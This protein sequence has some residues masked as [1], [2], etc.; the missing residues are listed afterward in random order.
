MS[1]TY[2]FKIIITI[3]ITIIIFLSF[4]ETSESQVNVYDNDYFTIENEETTIN[5]DNKKDKLG[6]V[7]SAFESKVFIENLGQLTRKIPFN[8][9]TVK[10]YANEENVKMMFDPKGIT[11]EI[12][13]IEIDENAYEEWMEE[14]LN[15]YKSYQDKDRHEVEKEKKLKEKIYTFTYDYIRMEWEN[16]GDDVQIVP[17]DEGTEKFHFFNYDDQNNSVYGARGYKK[18][19]IKNL[20]PGINVIYSF[21][22]EEGVKYR[23]DLEPGADPFF[24]IMTYSGQV[25]LIKDKNGNIVLRSSKGTV[26]DHAP[27]SWQLSQANIIASEFTINENSVGFNLTGIDPSLPVTIDPWVVNITGGTINKG[28]QINCDAA[29]NTYVYG[30][31]TNLSLRK[32]DLVGT[33]L[34]TYDAGWGGSFWPG[35]M[36]VETNGT[37]YICNA[38]AQGWMQKIDNNGNNIFNNMNGCNNFELFC[39][40]FNND[41]SQLVSGTYA[42]DWGTRVINT[43]DGTCSN[44]IDDNSS[45]EL[46]GLAISPE[47]NWYSLSEGTNTMAGSEVIAFAPDFTNI[48]KLPS[49]YDWSNFPYSGPS[50]AGVQSI[51]GGY[52]PGGQNCIDASWCWFY[53]YN[54]KTIMKRDALT[55]ALISQINVPDGDVHE[56]NSGGMF[57]DIITENSGIIV[58]SCDN[59]FVGTTVGIDKYDRDLNFITS[60]ATPAEVY[61]VNFDGLGN[62]VACGNGFAGAFDGLDP[63]LE[64]PIILDIVGTDAYCG[65][66]GTAT[67]DI[68]NNCNFDLEYLWNTG[69]TTDSIGELCEG[70]YWLTVTHECRQWTDSV[71]IEGTAPVDFF[72][73]FDVDSASCNLANGSATAWPQNG[74]GDYIYEWNTVPPQYEQT[75]INLAAGQYIVTVFDNGNYCEVTDT[76]TI[77]Q[78]TLLTPGMDV[79]HI[80][81][82]GECDGM[83]TATTT[84]GGAPPVSWQWDTNPVQTTETITGLCAGI[85]TVIIT[86]ANGCTF[87]AGDTITEPPLLITTTT[88]TNLSCYESCDGTA[89]V[90]ANGGTPPYTFSWNTIPVQ[91][92]SDATNLCAGDYTVI[93]TDANGCTSS[94]TVTLLQPTPLTSTITSTD[95]LC[96]GGDLGTIDLYVEGGTPPY[97]YFWQPDSETSQDLNG[98][99]AGDYSV[100]ITDANGCTTTDGILIQEPYPIETTMNGTNLLCFEDAA[101][102]SASV[103]ATGGTQPYTYL[104]SNGQVS[105]LIY[106]IQAGTYYV[107]VT[108]ANG[109]TAVDNIII[110]EPPELVVVIP[111]PE[112]ICIGETVNLIANVSGGTLPYSYYWNNGITTQTNSVSP[113]IT[114]SYNVQVTDAGNCQDYTSVNVAVHP[115]LSIDINVIDDSICP[116]DAVYI[117]AQYQGGMGEPYTLIMDNAAQVDIPVMIT[118]TVTQNYVICVTDECTTPEACDTVTV[119][120]LPIPS[121]TINSDVTEGCEPLTVY[122]NAYSDENLSYLWDFND[123]YSNGVSTINNP[124]HIFEEP[125]TYDIT[126]TFTSEYGCEN[127]LIQEDMITVYPLPVANFLPVPAVTTILKPW[128]YFENLSSTTYLSFWDFGDGEQSIETEPYHEYEN[129][130][131][132]LVELIIQ[133]EHFCPDTALSTVIVHDVNTFYAPTAF[134][135]DFDQVNSLFSP[136]G[137]G[138]DPDNWYM[139]IYD[140]W[141]EK[142]FETDIYDVDEE[143]Y[144]VNHGWDGRIKGEEPGETGTYAWLVIYRDATGAEHQHSGLV[145]LVR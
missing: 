102:S 89:S 131:T 4:A 50:Y 113:V 135:P 87:T 122:F 115:P 101:N 77:Y 3:K 141:G 123:E 29:G 44:A 94:N 112:T 38:L 85:Y 10:Y 98:I 26:I 107:T 96:N 111:D 46:R 114:D 73:L 33:P 35:D 49:G 128:V 56:D 83:A 65:C 31:I 143:T 139:A 108:D 53:T 80:S 48:F 120:V 133:T 130:G 32:F 41:Q 13:N 8:T 36:E 9:E 64:T 70:T 66:T 69:E 67:A 90:T 121:A 24:I 119:D 51:F 74:T 61:D 106:N 68:I 52:V 2:F 25:S 140:R 104:W 47:G 15:G 58:D 103:T 21:H 34:W 132:F 99:P 100:I 145:T 93:T 95:V 126:L 76:V 28:I 22:P 105:N 118:P 54:G 124:V 134:S 23:F 6:W 5:S 75:A 59:I 16:A 57:P 125:G 27:I 55:G 63:V 14:E 30:N 81:C 129:V 144:K 110:T 78:D 84:N 62:V 1:T 20:Y 117:Y 39:L 12:R 92:A 82:N 72:I 97:T 79:T 136:V 116:G 40:E 19:L 91:T 18:L 88:I 60:V 11:W 71:V 37:A 86:D 137:H 7:H 138:I 42:G 142:V 109:C 43:N 17:F 45:N 127:E